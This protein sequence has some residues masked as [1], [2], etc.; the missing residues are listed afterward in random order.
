MVLAQKS[1]DVIMA[2]LRLLLV[3]LLCAAP[4]MAADLSKID[5]TLA[6]E[7]KYQSNPQYCLL[8]FGPEAKTRV[9]LVLDRDVLYVDR[10]GNGDL[11]E[12]GK[13]ARVATPNQDPAS[14]EDIE[15]LDGKTTHRFGFF[16][17]GWF[18]LKFGKG[19]RLEPALDITWKDQ[20]RYGAWGDERS[21]LVFASRPEDAPIVHIG[22]PL[23]MGFEIRSP[24]ERQ[25]KQSYKLSAGVG[26]P[27][28]GP[29]TFAHLRYNVIP[30]GVYPRATLE[31]PSKAIGGTPVKVEMVLRERC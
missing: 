9:W 30:E 8:V 24:L 22:G 3:L 21:P 1:E 4:V 26:T 17:Y 6:K 14:F 7:P 18:S 23:R 12:P 16:L 29:G 25:A 2:H 5:R 31:F 10:N 13:Q 27:G 11:T 20:Q 28:L 19:G 15:I